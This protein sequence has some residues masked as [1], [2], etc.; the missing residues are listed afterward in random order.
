MK[1]L[2]TL[3]LFVSS[4]CIGQDSSSTKSSIKDFEELIT[5]S[6]E[7]K[8]NKRINRR[9]NGTE[10]RLLVI[11][12]GSLNQRIT[13]PRYL[14]QVFISWG[15]NK[16]QL[17]KSVVLFI[18]KSKSKLKLYIGNEVTKIISKDDK[19]KILEEEIEPKIE[20]SDF[21]GAI[22]NGVKAILNF[23]K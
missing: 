14:Q 1:I 16:S 15:I 8:I 12:S 21:K 19:K 17:S 18:S 22:A 7:K 10:Y 5:E 9:L 2:V 23:F 13:I 20:K 11:T 3:F 6:F 4:F